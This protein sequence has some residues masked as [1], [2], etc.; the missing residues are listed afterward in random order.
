[1]EYIRR[2]YPQKDTGYLL[3]TSDNLTISGSGLAKA[4]AAIDWS[5]FARFKGHFGFFAALGASR[6]KHL[7]PGAADAFCSGDR[8]DSAWVHW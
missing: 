3:D 1:M 8:Q 6:G 2:V 4:L 7:S 5:T